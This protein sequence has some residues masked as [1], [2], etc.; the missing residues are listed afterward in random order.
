VLVLAETAQYLIKFGQF[1]L[2]H[3]CVRLAKDCERAGT[4]KAQARNKPA[5][6][7]PYIKY[8]LKRA[9]AESTWDFLDAASVL[10]AGDDSH[11]PAIDGN[12]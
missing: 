9:E 11:N 6:T 1:H 5:I 7:P 2:A 3:A 8:M 10:A 12:Q 4:E